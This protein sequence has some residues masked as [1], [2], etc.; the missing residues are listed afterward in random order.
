MAAR[1]EWRPAARLHWRP[2]VRL[3]THFSRNAA[4]GRVGCIEQSASTSPP[5]SHPGV[6]RRR[7]TAAV[8]TGQQP[9]QAQ[10]SDGVK[11]AARAL[12]YRPHVPD[13]PIR[14]TLPSQP[15]STCEHR[16]ATTALAATI[17]R[18]G[19]H[20]KTPKKP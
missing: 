6:E 4:A 8:P 7:W 1:E 20:E 15:L 2:A 10:A 11:L 16:P 14:W 19:W 5:M 12:S 13:A 9:A 17:A 18:T 3:S